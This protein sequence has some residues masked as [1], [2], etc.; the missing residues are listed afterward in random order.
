MFCNKLIE[1]RAYGYCDE[2]CFFLKN[3]T[4]KNQKKTLAFGQ[5]PVHESK[6]HYGACEKLT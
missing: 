3:W 2:G 1:R 4:A 5:G 6:D